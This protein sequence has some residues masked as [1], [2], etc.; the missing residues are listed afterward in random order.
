MISVRW[1]VGLMI[2]LVFFAAVL[3]TIASEIVGAQNNA[4]ITGASNTILGLVVLIVV[5][6]VVAKIAGKV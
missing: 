1:T 3:P 2:G 5:G 6:V 4:N